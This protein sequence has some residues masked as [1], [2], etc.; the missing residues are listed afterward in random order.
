MSAVAHVCAS[1]SVL[2]ALLPFSVALAQQAAAP[3]AA[4]PV[5]PELLEKRLQFVETAPGELAE[6]G[7]QLML[8]MRELLAKKEVKA[9]ELRKVCEITNRKTL[10]TYDGYLK[11]V[12]L[13]SATEMQ[14]A[15][16]AEQRARLEK[17]R[18]AAGQ[19]SPQLDCA[20]LEAR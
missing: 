12:A 4:K 11:L 17:A 9:S 16:S 5:D 8:G 7:D 10:E 19:A 1:L 18:P 15:M 2:M 3:A 14:A 13:L 20:S 6:A